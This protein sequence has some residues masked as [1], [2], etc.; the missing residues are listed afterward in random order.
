MSNIFLLAILACSE[1]PKPAAEIAPEVVIANE[2][3]QGSQAIKMGEF[4]SFAHNLSGSCTLYTN[5]SGQRTIRLEKF[6]MSMGP[7]VYVF[8]SKSNNYSKANAISIGKLSSTYTS[9]GLNIN[10]DSS[11]DLDQYKFVL[12]YCVQYNSLFGFAELK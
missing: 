11:I 3:P 2:P 4:E 10:T 12:V 6:S 5:S 1:D 8:V 7:D 9:M